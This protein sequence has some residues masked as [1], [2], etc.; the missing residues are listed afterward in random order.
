MAPDKNKP[1]D[2][3]VYLF[4]VIVVIDAHV[5]PPEQ[6]G[7]TSVQRGEEIKDMKDLKM[8][9][10]PYCRNRSETT[11]KKSDTKVFFLA[12]TLR[13]KNL[14]KLTEYQRKEYE[15][16]IP[17]IWFPKNDLNKEFDTDVHIITEIGG[18]GLNF[19]FDWTFDEMEDIIDELLSKEEKEKHGK[20]LE[21]LINEKV[22]EQKK[23]NRDEKEAIKA[24]ITSLS[25][26]ERNSLDNLKCYKYYP[27]NDY[28]PIERTGFINRYYGK[29]AEV[30]PPVQEA[31][32]YSNLKEII[33]TVTKE[34][35]KEEK[36][37]EKKEEKKQEK[38]QEKSN[39]KKKE[40]KKAESD[41]E[42]TEMEEEQKGT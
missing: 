9:W 36:T 16:A 19:S 2:R 32:D 24:K 15:Y 1:E 33:P 22:K 26:K 23:K 4:P 35:N 27:Q 20:E 7:I 6:L 3:E 5:P 34:E 39:N 41:E 10:A 21:N 30:F 29:A 25:E 13:R 12:C 38:K 18:R 42:M 37:E 17:Y 31:F 40:E 28:Y 11:Y 14:D 8:E